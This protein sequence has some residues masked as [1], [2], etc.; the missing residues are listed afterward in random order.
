MNHRKNTKKT[1]DD[2][3]D[4][5]RR[6]SLEDIEAARERVRERLGFKNR[7]IPASSRS[8]F[9]LDTNTASFW[10]PRHTY[11]AAAAALALAVVSI[12]VFRSNSSDNGA[13]FTR[14]STAPLPP[15]FVPDAFEAATVRRANAAPARGRRDTRI[16]VSDCTMSSPEIDPERFA[17]ESTTVYNLIAWAYGTGDIS[18]AG[19]KKIRS[20]NLVSGGPAWIRSEQWDVEAIMP[21]G[22]R[23]YTQEQLRKGQAPGFRRMLQ[24]LLEDGFKVVVRHE[25]KDIEAW[26]LTAEQGAPRLNLPP[27]GAPSGVVQ[28]RGAIFV[29]RAPMSDFI[30][31]LEQ[32]MSRPVLDRTGLRGPFSFLVEYTARDPI[33]HALQEQVGLKLEPVKTTVD[34]W[35]IERAEKPGED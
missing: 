13:V 16:S 23:S 1:L 14:R 8:E 11:L 30:P 4:R 20:L 25:T 10:K 21:E 28:E 15:I 9:S 24:L 33:Q 29:R 17:V 32:E 18:P 27:D 12:S 22:S 26:A 19:C 3:F 5:L 34:V 2:A 6:R 31:L 7:A 35:V